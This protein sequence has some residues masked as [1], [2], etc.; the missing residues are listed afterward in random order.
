MGQFVRIQHQMNPGHIH[1]FKTFFKV[2]VILLL[3]VDFIQQFVA[4]VFFFNQF[5]FGDQISFFNNLTA[6]VQQMVQPYQRK[7]R[8]TE[9]FQRQ[10]CR[11]HIENKEI[12]IGINI[13]D[14]LIGEKY[15]VLLQSR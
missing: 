9:K 15:G 12:K 8:Q 7:G 1:G 5:D 3:F 10:C 4:F 6:Q 13:A 11:R 14:M 2:L